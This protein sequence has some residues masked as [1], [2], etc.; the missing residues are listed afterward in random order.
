MSLSRTRTG[1]LYV[2]FE[3]ILWSLFPVLSRFSVQSFPPLFTAGL[4]TL[5]SSLFFAGV[6]TFK[7][8]WHELGV[9]AAWKDILLVTL[10]IG[11][12]FYAILFIGLRYTTAGNASIM[13]LM[14]VFFSF[15]ILGV[16]LRHEYVRLRQVIGAI[17]MVG[18]ALLVLLPKTAGWHGGDILIALGTIFTPLGNRYAQRAREKV[19]SECIMFVRSMVSGIVLL[20]LSVFV[21]PLTTI[22]N[23][24]SGMTL[25]V[26]LLNGFL[27][28][29]YSKL[30]W[31]EAVY[32]IPISKAI[33]L[34]SIA[35]F[36]TFLFA[37]LLLGE[38]MSLWQMA[39]LFPILLGVY[40]LTR[41]SGDHIHSVV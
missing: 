5:I 31:V 15:S 40:L 19:S 1:E 30:L 7:K 38:Q 23:I 3:A 27:V 6:L 22:Q 8:E 24:P 39:S 4:S 17:C 36:F 35:P 11:V 41:S 20:I 18:G 9:R 2:F 28:L 32:L 25:T 29:G 12:V 21:E 34:A 26:F 13:A 14:E 16:F 10:Y 33:S 37:Y